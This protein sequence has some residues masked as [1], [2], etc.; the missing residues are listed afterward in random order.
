M[1]QR[2]SLHEGGPRFALRIRFLDFLAV[3]AGHFAW[4]KRRTTGK[5]SR[6]DPKIGYPMWLF[7]AKVE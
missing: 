4:T 2:A 5:Y 7:V 6:S 1:H 3:F